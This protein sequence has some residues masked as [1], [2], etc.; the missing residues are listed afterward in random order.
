MNALDIACILLFILSLWLGWKIQ[1]I[2]MLTIAA[3][4][5]LGAWSAQHFQGR[6]LEGF[7]EHVAPRAAAF[8]SWFTPFL[9]TGILVYLLGTMT[10]ALAEAIQL[11][12]LD[13]L[14]GALIAG[15]LTLT[16]LAAGLEI[17]QSS[18][19]KNHWKPGQSLLAKPLLQTAQPLLQSSRELWH[20]LEQALAPKKDF[21]K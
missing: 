10:A 13:H 17:S 21:L 6:L 18:P 9:M 19:R 5:V 1:G 11:K 2:R 14:L 12:W 16:L 15:L 3:A 4:I 8:L 20:A 7:Q